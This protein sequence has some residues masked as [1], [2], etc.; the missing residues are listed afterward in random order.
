MRNSRVA[1]QGFLFPIVPTFV[2]V[3]PKGTPFPYIQ[4]NYIESG[5]GESVLQSA[6]LYSNQSVFTEAETIVDN[7]DRAIGHGGVK[8]DLDGG[9][10]LTVHKGNPFA[11]HYPQPEGDAILAILINFELRTYQSH[12]PVEPEKEVEFVINTLPRRPNVD[13]RWINDGTQWNDTLFW[14]E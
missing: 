6:V 5:F 7:I 4:L 13:Y 1:F 2:G 8:L 11:Q 9:G 14:V 3:I 12:K 10:Y